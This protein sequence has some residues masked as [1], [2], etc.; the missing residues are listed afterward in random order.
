MKRKRKARAPAQDTS[1]K[2]QGRPGP[3]ENARKRQKLAQPKSGKSTRIRQPVLSSFYPSTCSLR[4]YLLSVLKR[5]GASKRRRRALQDVKYAI[6]KPGGDQAAAR[7]VVDAD[8]EFAVDDQT[9]RLLD[10][11]IVGVS[12]PAKGTTVDAAN[13]RDQAF[14]EYTQQ[15]S[16]SLSGGTGRSATGS[17][18]TM[19]EVR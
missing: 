1:D 7:A 8:G 2:E 19:H 14:E 11:V 4:E 6:A 5:S 13:G 12:D 9:V 10:R 17:G 3:Q 18:N 16:A 15:V